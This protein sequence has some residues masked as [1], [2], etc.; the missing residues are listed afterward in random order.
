LEP[1]LVH[2]RNGRKN[3]TSLKIDRICISHLYKNHLTFHNPGNPCCPVHEPAHNR[4][5]GTSSQ[6]SFAHLCND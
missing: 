4:Y 2:A 1:L 5:D 3:R 6:T